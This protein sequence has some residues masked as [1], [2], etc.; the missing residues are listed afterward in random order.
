MGF[1]DLFAPET[2]DRRNRQRAMLEMGRGMAPNI[3]DPRLRGLLESDDIAKVQAGMGLLDEYRGQQLKQLVGQPSQT[4][5][6]GSG[7]GM[8]EN[9]PATGLMGGLEKNDPNA[10]R[11]FFAQLPTLGGQYVKAG[12]EG[13]TDTVPKPMQPTEFVRNAMAAGIMP[14]TPEF[15]KLFN[16]KYADGGRGSYSQ[17]AYGPNGELLAFNTRNEKLTPLSLPG[18]P[19]VPAIG[20]QHNPKL[21]K[22]KTAASETAKADVEL[23]TDQRK[24]SVQ[25]GNMS[26]FIK[27]A[28]TLLND[29]SGGLAGT[30]WS[31]AKR[32]AGYSDKT[33]QANEQLKLI[34]GWMVSNVPRMEGPQS[35]FDVKN[36]MEMAAK[37]G[38]SMTPVEDRRAA[39]KQLEALQSKYLKPQTTQGNPQGNPQRKRV[40]VDAQGNP[41][42]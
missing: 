19:G 36:Y 28:N 22:D 24:K 23:E 35:E 30:A 25:A 5:T 33:T 32:V 8:L 2:V 41:I 39:L 18:S 11:N 20:A 1:L 27:Q 10:L 29:A 21:I 9:R 14:G 34:S 13:L 7:A 12:L 40:R 4:Y 26:D 42:P 38:D 16:D 3:Q 37:V 6:P 15:A 17:L 31:G